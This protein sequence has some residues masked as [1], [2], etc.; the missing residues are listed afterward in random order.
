MQTHKKK[1]QTEGNGLDLDMIISLSHPYT[2]QMKKRIRQKL[3]PFPH[4]RNQVKWVATLL[5]EREILLLGRLRFWG[6]SIGYSSGRKGKG[7][8][9]PCKIEIWG[10]PL[11]TLRELLPLGRLRFGGTQSVT[12]GEIEILGNS[13][14]NSFRRK[15][16]GASSPCEIE[17]WGSPLKTFVNSSRRW[18]V[19]LFSSAP[20]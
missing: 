5:A 4:P 17:I 16:K 10:S 7:A 18:G 1:N 14:S 15:G 2:G 9:F 6:I 8:S 3:L 19:I 11:R 12:L 13:V 20:R